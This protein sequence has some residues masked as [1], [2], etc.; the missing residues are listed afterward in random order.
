[1]PRKRVIDPK[2]WTDDKI[3]ELSSNEL[4]TF[5]GMMTF[6][7]DR[8]IHKYNVKVLKAEIFPARE[9]INSDMVGDYIK[10]LLSKEL[11]Q[12]STD[13]KLLRY[14]NWDT[15]QKIQ[16]KTKSK[17]EDEEGNILVE[18]IYK[19]N[20]GI[21]EV[22]HN[23]ININNIK[24][25]NISSNNVKENNT[26]F[27]PKPYKEKVKEWYD[28]FLKDND[29]MN[30]FKETF[31]DVDIKQKL[32]ECYLWLSEPNV[33]KNKDKVFFNWCSKHSGKVTVEQQSNKLSYKDY[34]LDTTGNARIG[35]CSECY[36][37]AF[38]DIYKIHQIESECCGKQLNPT[39]ENVNAK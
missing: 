10:T 26:T 11:L 3:I 9:D 38:Y 19:Y 28:S 37:S 21:E 13:N 36:R 27:K 2:I 4:L 22:S 30:T 23:I 20:T 17:Y 7:D 25:N 32:T 18:F 15:Y 35:Y 39:K 31:P 6:S 29:K 34:K 14:T 1:M 33:R 16:H 12:I 8:G 5:I 24:E